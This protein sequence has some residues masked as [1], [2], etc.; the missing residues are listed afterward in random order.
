VK[1]L[2]KEAEAQKLPVNLAFGGVDRAV[3]LLETGKAKEAL[4]AL[5]EVTA[6]TEKDPL[7][8]ESLSAV[9]RLGLVV[10][11]TAEEKLGKKDDIAK[12]LAALET[13]VGKRPDSAPAQSQIEYVK[14]VAAS[15]AGDAKGAAAHFDKCVAEQAYCKWRLMT[16]L[17]KSGDKAG[18]AAAKQKLVDTPT[19]D[20]MYLYV[21]AK[22]GTIAKP[23][24]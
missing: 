19:R 21:R 3:F 24:K 16:A 1:A 13:E 14:G 12:T 22:L 4:K 23:K 10:R 6:R 15:A 7:P 2:E 18:A 5:D 11:A 8:G 20:T 17:E 9:R